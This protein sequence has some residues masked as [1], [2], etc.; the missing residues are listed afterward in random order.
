MQLADRF[1]GVFQRLCMLFESSFVSE[2]DFLEFV[3]YA[4][5]SGL[6]TILALFSRVEFNV[7]DQRG[8]S[9]KCKIYLIYFMR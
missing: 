9:C 5:I 4:I 8:P 2:L 6:E 3:N 7:S 1:I